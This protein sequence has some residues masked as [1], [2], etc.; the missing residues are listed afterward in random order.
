MKHREIYKDIY[1]VS[2]DSQEELA[3]TFLRFQEHYESPNF[4]GRYFSLNE[5]KTWYAQQN[6]S[7]SY[8]EDWSGFNVP[9]YILEPFRFGL[10]GELSNL[11]A[12]FLSVFDDTDRRY[13]IIGTNDDGATLDHEICHALFYV[14]NLY[15]ESV[16]AI[17]KANKDA[18]SPLFNQ[19]LS[20]GY[21]EA[22]LIDEANAYLCA[23]PDWIEEQGVMVD[24]N[25][26]KQLQQLRDEAL[27]RRS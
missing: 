12:K 15:R 18:L 9:S 7:F 20:L 21:H 22:V 26:V 23:N 5:Y 4:R 27:N 2:F 13:Y 17:I 11:E 1:H 8:V 3:M 6:G 14:D 25:L 19:I 16:E 24:H 10:F